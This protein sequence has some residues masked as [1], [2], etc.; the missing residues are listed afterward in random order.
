MN[1]AVSASPAGAATLRVSRWSARVRPRLTAAIGRSEPG[2]GERVAVAGVHHQRRPDDEHRVGLRQR[3]R[4][5][6]VPPRRD[7]LPEEDHVGLDD[8]AAAR[9]R[10][11]R[12]TSR[13]RARRGRRRRPAR[14]ARRARPR[15]RLSADRCCLPAG[16]TRRLPAGHAG[17]P[18]EPA[19]QVDD[20]A[21]AGRLVQPVDVLRH[22][23]PDECR[24]ARPRR[25]GAV[26]VVGLGRAEAAP[27]DQTTRPVAGPHHRVTHERL[28][29]DRSLPLPLPVEP[30]IVRDPRLG[31]AARAGEDEH[32]SPSGRGTR[33][34]SPDSQT[35][36]SISGTASRRPAGIAH[37]AH[38]S[39]SVL[40]CFGDRACRNRWIS[41]SSIAGGFR[42][43][44]PPKA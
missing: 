28:E 39:S 33:R 7:V 26:R 24:A 32:A 12:R 8:A 2:R 19:V 18:V 25:E 3:R 37:D 30:A 4:R 36:G 23:Q 16:P 13:S 20:P 31:A 14:P 35:G 21:R 10:P 27:A 40:G 44:R 34:S 5:L 41:T 43:A 11:A 29:L 1:A 15:S 17:H 22:E 9:D 6:G 42:Q 38:D